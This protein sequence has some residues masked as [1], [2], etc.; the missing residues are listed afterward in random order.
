MTVSIYLAHKV[1]PF[2]LVQER[3]ATTTPWSQCSKIK[4][5]T[6]RKANRDRPQA[7]SGSQVSDI[8]ASHNCTCPETYAA[9]YLG[10]YSAWVVWEYPRRGSMETIILG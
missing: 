9:Y 4:T 6:H 5:R 7:G 8:C 1:G 3:V 10:S 2:Q